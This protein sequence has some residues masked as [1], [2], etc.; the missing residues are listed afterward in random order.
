MVLNPER[1]GITGNLPGGAVERG[2]CFLVGHGGSR[3]RNRER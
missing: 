3:D 1:I 2:F